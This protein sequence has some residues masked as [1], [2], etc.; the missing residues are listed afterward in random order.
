L[1]PRRSVDPLNLAGVFQRSFLETLS[2]SPTL[3]VG[4]GSCRRELVS[5]TNDEGVRE[6]HLED[7][8]ERRR[9]SNSGDMATMN[10][11]GHGGKKGIPQL[12]AE[13]SKSMM[14]MHTKDNLWGTHSASLRNATLR[15]RE[16]FAL[17]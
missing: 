15:P 5:R 16:K 2:R 6:A 13:R 7:E 10:P 17:S 4:A 1:K 14:G 9:R 3:V 8:K 11:P 12:P